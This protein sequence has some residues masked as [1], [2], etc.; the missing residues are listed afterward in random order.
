M[1]EP[2]RKQRKGIHLPELVSVK[3]PTISDAGLH[4]S[5]VLRVMGGKVPT[6]VSFEE[7]ATGSSRS[8]GRWHGDFSGRPALIGSFFKHIE[9]KYSQ[10]TAASAINLVQKL[11]TWWRLFDKFDA[12]AP[13]HKVEDI[14]EGHAAFARSE[15]MDS[16]C[17]ASLA[18]LVNAARSDLMLPR[19]YWLPIGHPTPSTAEL[20]DP[21]HVRA[22]YITVK[23]RVYRIRERWARADRY[24]QT[25]KDWSKE[26]DLRTYNQRWPVEDVYATAVGAIKALNHPWP[27]MD[28]F[29]TYFNRGGNWIGQSCVSF[30]EVQCGLYPD[31]NDICDFLLFF[32]IR[33]GWNQATAL[34]IDISNDSWFELNPLSPMF[35][36]VKAFKARNQTYQVTIGLEKSPISPGNIIREL[37]AR[38][39]P[40]RA[41]LR[42]DLAKLQSKL[43]TLRVAPLD[44]VTPTEL[45]ELETSI[46]KLT[47]AIASPWIYVSPRGRGISV[48]SEN[49]LSA[50]KYQVASGV[51][52][53]YMRKLISEANAINKVETPIPDSIT[54]GDFRDAYIAFAYRTSG[55]N[56][57][58]AMLAA[59][60]K[61]VESLKTYLRHRQWRA[62]SA[63]KVVQFGNALWSEIIVHKRV[64]PAILFAMVERGE[65]TQDQCERWLQH[66][67]RTRL[68]VGCKNVRNP[69]GDI[70]QNHKAGTACRVHRCTLCQHAVIFDDSMDGI[71]LRLAELISIK[72]RIPLSTWH[73]SSFERELV[74]TEE[75][76]TLFDSHLV[77]QAVD[78]WKTEIECGRHVPMMFEGSYA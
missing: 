62:H 44:Q 18:S 28:Q 57:L 19:L 11:R 48:L 63:K 36:I 68:G 13:V 56:W 27:S 40:L 78:K 50:V 46:S 7:F 3:P 49:G 24:V 38:T 76:L 2:S 70:V 77:Q 37:I 21:I 51:Q 12:L 33:T 45:E 32:L 67:D 66:K 10:K 60:H 55:Y 14:H 42:K 53:T 75:T 64:E 16:V 54:A 15:Q 74:I 6:N 43:E 58:V 8:A 39:E 59:G 71:A 20:P 31:L 52:T 35:H 17:Y 9:I 34:N 29:Q 25:G 22:I 65:V 73:A 47:V 69:P 1:T 23:H 41:H 72:S 30:T 26:M 5:L 4:Q 61:S